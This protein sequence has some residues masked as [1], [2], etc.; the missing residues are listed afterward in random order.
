MIACGRDLSEAMGLAMEVESL[1]EQYWRALQ[2]GEP[3][4]LSEAQMDEVM[5][6]FRGYWRR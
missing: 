3:L 4:I 1:C 5:E 6:K 2:V